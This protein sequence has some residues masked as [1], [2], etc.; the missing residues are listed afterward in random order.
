[1]TAQEIVRAIVSG[2]FNADEV[3][4]FYD[5]Y[6]FAS[7]QLA[8]RATFTLRRGDKVKFTGR[9]GREITGMVSDV[10]I[11]NVIVDTGTTRYRVPASMLS[12]V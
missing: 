10:K 1:M 11:K 8:R 2:N 5:A 6:K 3:R 4:S 7:N 9:S 12:A